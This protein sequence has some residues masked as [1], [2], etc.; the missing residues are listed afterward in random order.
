ME[1]NKTK[2]KW[3]LC[4]EK[5]I[6]IHVQYKFTTQAKLLLKDSGCLEVGPSNT[7]KKENKFSFCFLYNT[8]KF[9]V[10]YEP[11]TPI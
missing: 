4:H 1:E 2:E 10:A 3:K 7:T 5:V 9:C 11:T 6:Q 8:I